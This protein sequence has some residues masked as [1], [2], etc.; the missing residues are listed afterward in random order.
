MANHMK[1]PKPKQRVVKAWI[2]RDLLT[3]RGREIHDST[4]KVFYGNSYSG[5][6]KVEVVFKKPE[7]PMFIPVTITFTPK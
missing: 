7:N 1:P 4:Q 6:G 5:I 3:K 2:H